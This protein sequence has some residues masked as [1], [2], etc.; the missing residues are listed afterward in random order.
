MMELLSGRSLASTSS[1]QRD[2][3]FDDFSDNECLRYEGTV[4][5][6]DELHTEVNYKSRKMRLVIDTSQDSSAG[7]WSP[8]Q[9]YRTLHDKL[10]SPER[11]KRS[12]SETKRLQEERF[13]NAQLNRG[14]IDSERQRRFQLKAERLKDVNE[15]N[16]RKLA[17]Q[18]EMMWAK[19]GRADALHEAHLRWIV[20]KAGSENTKVDEVGFIKSLTKENRK[21]SLNERLE[22]VTARRKQWL[23][24][25]KTRA[26]ENLENVRAASKRR[27]EKLESAIAEKHAANKK[28]HQDVETRKISLQLEMKQKIMDM[29]NKECIVKER[30]ENSENKRGKVRMEGN[31]KDSYGEP[32]IHCANESSSNHFKTRKKVM[33]QTAKRIRRKLAATSPGYQDSYF[34]FHIKVSEHVERHYER[35]LFKLDVDHD[36]CGNHLKLVSL[37]TQLETVGSALQDLLQFQEDKDE[38]ELHFFR[39]LGGIHRVAKWASRATAAVSRD[40]ATTALKALCSSCI[41]DANRDYLLATNCLP[42][43]VDLTVWSLNRGDDTELME[44]ALDA[45]TLPLRHHTTIQLE[46]VRQNVIP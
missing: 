46:T 36:F 40:V 10:S 19:L 22:N 39:C 12:P 28:R 8:T 31:A 9:S 42:E 15:R 6:C 4:M 17:L 25:I 27:D 35:L 41:L 43:L 2:D 32:A 23:Q 11:R 30:R 24:Q 45:V 37:S 16:A 14:K 26:S 3:V 7:E 13:F 5:T 20:R 18:E 1:L 29:A 38:R 44:S 34:A 21:A 33:R